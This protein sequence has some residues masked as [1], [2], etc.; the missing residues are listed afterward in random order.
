M[1]IIALTLAAFGL[2]AG[3]AEARPVS[4]DDILAEGGEAVRGARINILAPEPAV[5]LS[6]GEFRDLALTRCTDFRGNPCYGARAR[7]GASGGRAAAGE[8]MLAISLEEGFS[9]SN[10]SFNQGFIGKRAAAQSVIINGIAYRMSDLAS[11]ALTDR[12]IFISLDA[13]AA[14]GLS[15]RSFDIEALSAPLPAAGFLMAAALGGIAL[16]RRRSKKA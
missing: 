9:L 14:Q 2:L 10:L 13:L 1:R 16:A 4:F 3:S 5:T 7:Y 11:L 6:R 12:T 8:T 15:L